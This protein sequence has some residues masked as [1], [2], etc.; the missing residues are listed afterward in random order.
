MTFKRKIIL[1]L[2]L[3]VVTGEI[4]LSIDKTFS[5]MEENRIVKIPT[6]IEKTPE[7][8]MLISK[9]LPLDDSNQRI[10]VIGDSYIHGGGIEFHQNFSQQ[11]KK[12]YEADSL[13]NQKTWVLD[14]SK[15]S[16]NNLDNYMSY[17]QFAEDY[18]PD[19]VIVGYNLNDIE[20]NLEI[21]KVETSSH[22]QF[23]DREVAGKASVSG[24]KQLYKVIQTSK[25]LHFI[26]RRS[27]RTLN[28]YGIIFPNSKFDQLMKSY[29][30]DKDNWKQS[31]ALID[32][33]ANHAEENDIKLVYYKF[34][35]LSKYPQL[36]T[37][38]N[39]AIKSYFTSK[40]EI[41]YLDGNNHF[42]NSLSNSYRISKY[43]GHPNEAA[44]KKMAK[45]VY[46]YLN[47]DN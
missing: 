35:D 15:S 7:Y 33:I 14:V 5:P 37:E 8:N 9:S 19:I 41:I 12:L 18:K 43:D 25:V 47:S 2:I 34:A 27:H 26:L 16:S 46:D 30:L 29:Y 1:A 21:S 32:E 10:M 23:N 3:F 39:T 11:L 28:N 6:D 38:A 36:F 4:M 22:D 40:D 44:H 24:I 45:Y 17:F 31:K 13:S 20:G 42:D